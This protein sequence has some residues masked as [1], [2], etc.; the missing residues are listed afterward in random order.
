MSNRF[1]TWRFNRKW[2]VPSVII[3]FDIYIL[4]G[5]FLINPPFGGTSIYGN[6][7]IL[8]VYFFLKSIYRKARQSPAF[9]RLKVHGFSRQ[10]HLAHEYRAC[11]RWHGKEPKSSSQQDVR[12]WSRCSKVLP[13]FL[14]LY[15]FSFTS[16]SFSEEGQA[17]AVP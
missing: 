13:E 4:M 5:F 3:H 1:L 14:K 11:P 9:G 10:D 6:L 15:Y 12:L 7:H 17:V 2:G 8:I 16:N